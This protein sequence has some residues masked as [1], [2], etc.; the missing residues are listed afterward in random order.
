MSLFGIL[1]RYFTGSAF[2]P[3]DY[4]T[5]SSS[6][7]SDQIDGYT[8]EE[9]STDLGYSPF[10]SL[11]LSDSPA[12]L[13]LDFQRHSS[14]LVQYEV[15]CQRQTLNVHL[16]RQA[17]AIY[18]QFLELAKHFHGFRRELLQAANRL[19]LP[20][21]TQPV[22]G[23][24]SYLNDTIISRWFD[25]LCQQHPHITYVRSGFGE[26]FL[27][28]IKKGALQE[29]RQRLL[30]ANVIFLPREAGNHW[31]LAKIEKFP[32]N[33]FAITYLDGL[34]CANP[35]DEFLDF[36]QRLIFNLYGS[37]ALI[38][39]KK[40]VIPRQNNSIDCG[41]VICFHAQRLS[42]EQPKPFDGVDKV[43]SYTP[44]RLDMAQAIITNFSS[45]DLFINGDI[46]QGKRYR[47]SPNMSN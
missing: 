36:A 29:D 13:P 39:V 8:D 38:S 25:Y 14:L 40:E 10:S 31:Y 35:S 3:E 44:F 2:T 46:R 1:E 19:L 41:A 16:V 4:V 5:D 27:D 23:E 34:N 26:T 18:Q 24:N 12:D 20:F 11:S 37:D 7:E 22:L 28:D 32:S 33:H 42:D 45:E 17:Q 6:S 43:K 21:S 15:A 9:N 30:D 47:S